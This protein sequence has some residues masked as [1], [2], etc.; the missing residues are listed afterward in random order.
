MQPS[1]QLLVLLALLVPHVRTSASN[2]ET[3]RRNAIKPPRLVSKDGSWNIHGLWPGVPHILPDGGLARH[4]QCLIGNGT[5][6]DIGAG[7]GQY[8]AWF[9]NCSRP[10]PRW[11]GYDGAGNVEAI[12]ATGPPGAF[13]R[14]LNLCDNNS[15]VGV[16]DW[17]MS[18]EVGEHLPSN[19]IPNFISLLHQSNRKG[20]IL[21]WSNNPFGKGHISLRSKPEVAAVLAPLGYYSP[22]NLSDLIR[23]TAQMPWLKQNVQIFLR[24]E[25]AAPEFP[26][27]TR[28]TFYPNECRM[29]GEA[30]VVKV[31]DRKHGR[32]VSRI[33]KVPS[34]QGPTN[35]A[36]HEARCSCTETL[37]R[38]N[39]EWLRAQASVQ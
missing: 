21:S 22:T 31:W 18:L 7:A 12:S 23:K 11:T 15:I 26:Q 6:V 8:G 25:A 2:A 13:T 29:T 28:T 20:I 38:W 10:R 27:V 39:E 9:G 17:A 14:R 30:T 24:R 34:G 35:C 19:C 36:E 4:L 33:R 3:E 37:V 5:V 1:A 32:N 16:H